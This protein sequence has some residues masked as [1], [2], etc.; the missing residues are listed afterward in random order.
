MPQDISLVLRKILEG[1]IDLSYWPGH[2]GA[3]IYD[4]NPENP[5]T[6]KVGSVHIDYDPSPRG[7]KS[8]SSAIDE[9]SEEIFPPR[10][11]ESTLTVLNSDEANNTLEAQNTTNIGMPAELERTWLKRFARTMVIVSSHQH[12]RGV[13]HTCY[14]STEPLFPFQV[15]FHE[16]A[17]QDEACMEV[18][19]WA[20][21]YSESRL[22]WQEV[23]TAMLEWAARVI[24]TG[25]GHWAKQ[26]IMIEER[27]AARFWMLNDLRGP[28]TEGLMPS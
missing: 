16:H 6:S 9:M 10:G 19:R 8:S 2:V 26:D 13:A 25:D 15:R 24:R 3:M 14:P 23:A 18:Y 7:T 20:G 11:L 17:G 12:W 28:S 21:V 5:H 22:R 4:G 1:V 27:L